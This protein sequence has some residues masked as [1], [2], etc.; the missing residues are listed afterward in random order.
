MQLEAIKA[1]RGETKEQ[2]LPDKPLAQVLADAKQAKED[3]FQAQWKQMKTGASTVGTGAAADDKCRQPRLPAIAP[4]TR[5]LPVGMCHTS[6]AQL[7]DGCQP[8]QQM[9]TNT[10]AAPSG[11]TDLGH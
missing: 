5:L 2:E 10:A 3:A 7:W 4:C 6:S 9:Q 8:P 11:P 1:E